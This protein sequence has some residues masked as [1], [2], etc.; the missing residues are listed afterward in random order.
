MTVA[1]SIISRIQQAMS[2]FIRSLKAPEGLYLRHSASRPKVYMA[3]A[4]L[5][6][7]TTEFGIW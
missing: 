4:Q 2:F 1:Y 3:S 7:S 6:V 5:Q